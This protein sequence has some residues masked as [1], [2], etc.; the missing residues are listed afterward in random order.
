MNVPLPYR[1][2]TQTSI[3]FAV[4][5][6]HRALEASG[7]VG[8]KVQLM[9]D[10][11]WE[12]DS[13]RISTPDR[14]WCELGGLLSVPELVAGGLLDGG[15]ESPIEYQGDFPHLMDFVRQSRTG[16]DRRDRA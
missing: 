16:R 4:L 5:S 7:I 13:L 14:A 2:E 10:D 8:H 12:R 6:P 11:W 1:H 15:S 3:H 9:G